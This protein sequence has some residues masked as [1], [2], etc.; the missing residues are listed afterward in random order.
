MFS[1]PHSKNKIKK[2]LNQNYQQ[3][4]Y[5]RFMWWRWY[6]DKNKPLGY[7]ADFRDKIF[8]GDFDPSC[9]MWQVY[10]CEHM[11]ND[12]QEEAS[13]GQL[14]HTSEKVR[15]LKARR[16][17]LQEDHEKDENGKLDSLWT[18]F[19]KHFDITKKQAEE[20]AIKCR[21]EII[22]LYYIIEDKYRKQIKV[23]RRGRPKK[24][25]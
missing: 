5:N 4:N 10:L 7:K 13:D 1:V 23:S 8:N 16:K 14:D 22:D 3:I 11:L 24:Y 18:H 15:L 25:A 19:Q 20:E 9:Y 6:Q 17:R 12:L 21:G 2:H